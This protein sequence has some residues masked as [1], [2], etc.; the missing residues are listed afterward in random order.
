MIKKAR[1]SQY[2]GSGR[3]MGWLDSDDLAE[4]GHCWDAAYFTLETAIEEA[5]EYTAEFG[6]IQAIEYDFGTD[7]FVFSYPTLPDDHE[8]NFDPEIIAPVEIEGIDTVVY[9]M[10]LYYVEVA[11][12]S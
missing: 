1:V 12:E 3:R 10:P 4:N 11:H 6:T 5:A 2:T 9:R 8:R 7:C